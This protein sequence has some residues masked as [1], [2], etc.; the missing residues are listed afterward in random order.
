MDN[1]KPYKSELSLFC[2]KVHTLKKLL[3]L[4]L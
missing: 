4:L 3:L 1:K 2:G